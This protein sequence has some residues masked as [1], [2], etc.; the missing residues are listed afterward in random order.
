LGRYPTDSERAPLARALAPGFERRLVPLEEIRL[1]EPLPRF[2]RI[3]WSNHLTQEANAVALELENRSRLKPPADPRL[4][5]DWRE[6]FED[7][8]WS[9]INLREFVWMP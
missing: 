9:I 6:A 8:V 3:T 1:P 2:P 7:V 5:N 4:R